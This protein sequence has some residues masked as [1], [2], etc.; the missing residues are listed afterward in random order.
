MPI[1]QPLDNCQTGAGAVECRVVVQPREQLE[2]VIGMPHVE[3][4]TVVAHHVLRHI[5]DPLDT[6]FNPRTLTPR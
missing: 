2:Q 1:D 5:A 6:D 4:D 3:A